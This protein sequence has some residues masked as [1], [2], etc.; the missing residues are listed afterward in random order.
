VKTLNP[1][2]RTD[3]EWIWSKAIEA[4]K[5]RLS[6]AVAI[7]IAMISLTGYGLA[8]KMPVVVFAAAAF[9]ILLMV[10][11]LYV[12]LRFSVPFVYAVLMDDVALNSKE[13][14][15]Q[16]FLNFGKPNTAIGEIIAMSPGIS[17]QRAF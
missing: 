10:V 14:V 3:L 1:A 8:N 9:P 11:D 6:L 15:A 7:L 2:E 5:A 17:R 13:H 4:Y 16:I 12:A